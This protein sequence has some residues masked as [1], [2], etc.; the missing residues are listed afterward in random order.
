MMWIMPT[1]CTILDV[2]MW[3]RASKLDNGHKFL[4][5][6]P[7]PGMVE[8]ISPSITFGRGILRSTWQHW[9]NDVLL[10]HYIHRL[11]CEKLL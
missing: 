2:S 7:T 1:T 9:G 10:H 5:K 6:I 8:A 3:I 11:R 4:I